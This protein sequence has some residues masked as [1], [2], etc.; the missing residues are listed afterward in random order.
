MI[1]ND[2]YEKI[3]KSLSDSNVGNRKERNIRDNIFVLNGVINSAIQK[4]SAPIDLEF[5]DIAKCFDTLKLSEVLN[6]IYDAGLWNENF[7]LLYL[8]NES[9]N[10]SIRTPF[11]YTDKFNIKD[12]V[13]Q[14]T[15]FGGLFC[16]VQMDKL[17]K[18]HTK[19]AS[20]CIITKT[21]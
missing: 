2:E 16:T 15:I 14:G 19:K 4:E 18:S 5:F 9:T 21:E 3:G 11:G 8:A 17:G 12:V 6:D 20:H 7:E 13:M 1:Y 10:V